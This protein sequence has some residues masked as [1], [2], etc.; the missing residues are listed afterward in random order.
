[1]ILNRIPMAVGA[2][3]SGSIFATYYTSEQ[4]QRRV[5]ELGNASLRIAN[6]VSTVGTIMIDYAYFMKV[7]QRNIN[8]NEIDGLMNRLEILQGEQ[9]IST[10]SKM[11][12][13]KKSEKLYWDNKISQTRNEMDIVSDELARLSS[14]GSSSSWSNV[15]K[16]NAKRLYELCRQNKG[17]YIKL[18]QHV[19]QLDHLVP[20]EYV[21]ALRPLLA[22]APRSTWES[23]QRVMQEDLGKGPLDLFTK[24]EKEPLASASLAQVHIAYDKN[25]KK[26]A[27]KVQHEGLRE[28]S[29][30]DM[31]AI[32]F[33][34]GMVSDLFEGFSYN[35]LAREMN[36]NLPLELNFNV[37]ASNL[38]KCKNILKE[39]AHGRSGEVVVPD[40][41]NSSNR[42]LVMSFENG[43]YINDVESISEMGL[44]NGDVARIIST[45][46]CEQMYRHGFVHC[47]PHEAN[48]LVRPHPTLT[49]KP[50]VILLDHGLYKILNEDFRKNYCRLW[51][52]IVTS[53]EEEIK[54]RC[55]LMNAGKLYTLLAAMLTMKPWDDIVSDDMSRL[56]SKGTKGEAE[57][58][59]SYA[60]KYMKEVIGLL[61]AVPS[62]M[63]L[64][65]KT[66]DC[67]RHLDRSLG[68]PINTA[69]IV[70]ET[71][72]KII[73]EE[74][75]IQARSIVDRLSVVVSYLNCMVR[76]IALKVIDFWM[77]WNKV[78]AFSW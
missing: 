68:V 66:N 62:E 52:A 71:T 30:G 43:K 23:I 63:L 78:F 15:H 33:L 35:W 6:L 31:A 32:T 65:L 13:N 51:K 3:T 67:L 18:G 72:A 10:K 45:T 5:K 61:G 28:G 74:D 29:A 37:E 48:L 14:T 25:G 59:R 46:F 27:V 49:G 53:D 55:T 11:K 34:V 41:H 21:D 54:Y 36:A 7:A 58:L 44:K 20:D 47:D 64:L 1:M 77:S 9:E 50:Q 42:V 38:T 16:R 75:L 69:Q 8:E 57:M 12:T 73:F 70:A 60:K 26:Y 19:S 39:S 22:D 4:D 40:L 76:V 56:K 2:L 17:I 24:F